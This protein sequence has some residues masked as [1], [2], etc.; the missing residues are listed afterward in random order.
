[1]KIPKHRWSHNWYE[2]S[3]K[4]WEC[5]KS[6]SKDEET[7]EYCKCLDCQILSIRLCFK[8]QLWRDLNA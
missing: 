6:S 2:S 5:F 4:N 8:Y 7:A 3:E 1:M